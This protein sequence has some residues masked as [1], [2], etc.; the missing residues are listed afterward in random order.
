MDPYEVFKKLTAGAKFDYGRFRKDAE[1]LKILRP[2]VESEPKEVK[3][4]VK[5]SLSKMDKPSRIRFENQIHVSGTDIPCPFDTFEAAEKSLDKRI[6]GAMKQTFNF[7]A[8]TPIQMQ[9]WSI[10]AA[11]REIMACAPTGSGKTVAFMAPVI[12]SIIKMKKE[13]PSVKAIRSLILAPTR[14]LAKQIYGEGLRLSE[15]TGVRITYLQKVTAND[16]WAKKMAKNCDCL[17]TTP[18]RLIFLLQQ[19]PPLIS[20]S[21]VRWLVVDECDRLFETDNEQQNYHQQQNS[22]KKKQSI[23]KRALQ[24]FRDQLGIIF[25]ACDGNK[26]RRALFSA[27][28]S[29]DVEEWCLLNL[30]NAV[31]AYVGAKN[32]AAEKI[33][34]EL[35]FCGD[36]HGKLIALRNKIHENFEPP[37]LVFVQSKERAKELFAEL[38]YDG[39]NVE[40][41]HSDRTQQQRENIV[42]AFRE[43]KIWVLICTELMGRGIDFKGVRCVVNYDL[44]TSPI[45]YIHR[46]GRTG[47]MGR[48]GHAITY[49]TK[50]DAPFVKG[51][52]NVL[53]ESGCEVPEFFLK[54]GEQQNLDFRTKEERERAK[55]RA[56]KKGNS[57][58]KKAKKPKMNVPE[59]ETIRTL[60]QEDLT[61]IRKKK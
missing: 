45:A 26:L 47:R 20:L 15:G 35:V 3:P 34:Q 14:E 57:S 2:K 36:E 38:V 51:I 42:Q 31:Q 9:S 16:A 12:D 4:E 40:T 44:P 56:I 58:K 18:N 17:V 53:V 33:K 30:D 50:V 59:R 11:G 29:S 32:T 7:Q 8:P 61:R 60:P 55:K 49:F 48:A 13:E 39:I 10:M 25:G 54:M 6:I 19:E 52:A 43:G 37:M 23:Q 41:I 46:V 1:Q 24:S 27:T 28:F 21:H 22:S 5:A